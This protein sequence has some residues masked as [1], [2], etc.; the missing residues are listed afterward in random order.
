MRKILTIKHL[1]LFLN[2]LFI[3]GLSA[4]I[5]HG[6]TGNKPDEKSPY[7]FNIDQI[8]ENIF[9]SCELFEEGTKLYEQKDFKNAGLKFQE[10]LQK[11]RENSKASQY[12]KLCTETLS[13]NSSVTNENKADL[14]KIQDKPKIDQSKTTEEDVQ[15]LTNLLNRVKHLESKQDKPI[16]DT[17][18]KTLTSEKAVLQDEEKLQTEPD[19]LKAAVPSPAQQNKIDVKTEQDLAMAQKVRQS[20]LL[21]LQGNKYY[22]NLDYEKAYEF[23]KKALKV[24]DPS[25]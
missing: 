12:L 14:S 11:D 5:S 2:I 25:E 18:K 4:H 20:E 1:L 17:D 13:S 6:Q 9:L 22:E 7:S 16:T 8:A 21:M 24:L 10:A 23:Y 19:S 3:V 15:L